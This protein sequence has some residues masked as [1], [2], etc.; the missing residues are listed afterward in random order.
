MIKLVLELGAPLAQ[1]RQL[2]ARRHVTLHDFLSDRLAKVLKYGV[3]LFNE[4]HRFQKA[5]RD[6][7]FFPVVLR[8]F[9][10]TECP[11]IISRIGKCFARRAAVVD[12]FSTALRNAD[13]LTPAV[14]TF[15]QTPI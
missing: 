8:T 13:Q 2:A 11:L 9:F 14:S 15:E 5:R 6:F 7:G 10:R 1:A 4:T 12:V 3:V